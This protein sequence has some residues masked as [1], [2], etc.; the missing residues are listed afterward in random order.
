MHVCIHKHVCASV[1]YIKVVWRTYPTVSSNKCSVWFAF[2]AIVISVFSL[3]VRASLNTCPL[4]SQCSHCTQNRWQ[5]MLIIEQLIDQMEDVHLHASLNL[6]CLLSILQQNWQ[7]LLGRH[8]HVQ[9]IA[10][11]L[12]NW[13]TTTTLLI[14]PL[15]SKTTDY[16][17]WKHFLLYRFLS[18]KPNE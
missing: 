15:L 9:G 7:K 3:V 8:F 4:H 17:K 6:E 12:R 2:G 1:R 18:R 14:F 11:L 13:N 5:M 10:T 16:I